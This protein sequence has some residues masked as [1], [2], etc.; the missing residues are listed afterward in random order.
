MG[1]IDICLSE[2]RECGA[3]A[4]ASALNDVLCVGGSGKKYKI[5]TCKLV[6]PGDVE[7]PNGFDWPPRNGATEAVTGAGIEVV[8]CFS[9]WGGSLTEGEIEVLERHNATLYANK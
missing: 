4:G 9:G 1:D 7:L 6:V 8:G 5:W 2:E 3:K